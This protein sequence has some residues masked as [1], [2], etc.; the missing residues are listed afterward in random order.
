[1]TL[2]GISLL[3]ITRPRPRVLHIAALSV[4]DELRLGPKEAQARWLP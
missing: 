1:M 4:K 3:L 2:L